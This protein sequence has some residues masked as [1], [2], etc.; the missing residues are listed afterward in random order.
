MRGGLWC[1]LTVLLLLEEEE[2]EEEEDAPLEERRSTRG[3]PRSVPVPLSTTDSSRGCAHFSSSNALHAQSQPM[4][5]DQLAA[6]RPRADLAP[7]RNHCGH[8]TRWLRWRRTV[9]QARR[10]EM[11][12]PP[13]EERPTP[14]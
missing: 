11:D 8:S 10:E 5:G 4:N 9:G 12:A 2:D 6:R 1:H 3:D 13:A 7:R 14:P